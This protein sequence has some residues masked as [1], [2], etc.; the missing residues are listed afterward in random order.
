MIPAW[1]RAAAAHL[2]QS[3]VVDWQ[4]A[5]NVAAEAVLTGEPEL[6]LVVRSWQ[7]KADWIAWLAERQ[8]Y[9]SG[10]VPSPLDRQVVDWFLA[11]APALL[12]LPRVAR[13]EQVV[14]VR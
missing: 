1:R 6:M 8:Q 7:P 3:E 12:A 9:P 13:I 10:A 14:E 5:R 2:A 4:A 11:A